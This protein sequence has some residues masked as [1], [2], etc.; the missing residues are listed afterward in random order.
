M[1]LNPTPQPTTA[2]PTKSPLPYD[3]TDIDLQPCINT[4][5]RVVTFYERP[6]NQLQMTTNYYETKLYTEQKGYSFVAEKDMVMYEAGMAFTDMGSYQSITARVF[7]STGALLY[8]SESL[9]GKGET[10]T[11][12]SPR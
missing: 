1:T 6:D 8:E 7:D 9:A 2:S 4:T 3:C 11:F 5:D 10:E 12:G